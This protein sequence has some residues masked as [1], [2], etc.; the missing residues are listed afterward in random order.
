MDKIA[1]YQEVI[2]EILLEYQEFLQGS[3]IVR[4]NIL[5]AEVLLDAQHNHFQLLFLGWQGYQYIYNVALH[6]D[7]ID[8]KI[9]I[10][11]NNTEF[12][13]HN[14][15]MERGVARQEIVLGFIAPT[16]RQFTEQGDL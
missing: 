1:H 12:K 14:E 8:D 15:L 10:Q 5:K 13:I 7:I 2:A 4:N 9:W 6:L 16:E 3:S 11:Q